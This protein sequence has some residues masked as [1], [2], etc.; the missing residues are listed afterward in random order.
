MAQWLGYFAPDVMLRMMWD[1]QY[2]IGLDPDSCLDV[3][4]VLRYKDWLGDICK[5]I[6]YGSRIWLVSSY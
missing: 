5:G 6:E 4:E 1:I 3:V 2:E